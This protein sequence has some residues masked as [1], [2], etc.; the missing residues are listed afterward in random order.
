[1]CVIAVRGRALV[2]WT[3]SAKMGLLL[4]HGITSVVLLIL[5][6]Y[7]LMLMRVTTRAVNKISTQRYDSY[8]T[9]RTIIALTSFIKAW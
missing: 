2:D 7:S 8:E 5:C 4:S 3:K 6:V 1:M 9:C